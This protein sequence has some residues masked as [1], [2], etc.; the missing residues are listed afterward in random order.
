MSAVPVAAL[1]LVLLMLLDSYCSHETLLFPLFLF[2]WVRELP[3]ARGVGQGVLAGEV[4]RVKGA[5][6]CIEASN[7]LC[8]REWGPVQG[9]VPAGSRSCRLPSP[10]PQSQQRVCGHRRP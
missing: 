2:F 5:C 9:L 1:I 10:G 8:E 6:S 3:P 4:C 7:R